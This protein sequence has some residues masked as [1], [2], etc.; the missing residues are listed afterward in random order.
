MDYHASIGAMGGY[1][2]LKDSFYYGQPPASVY[3]PGFRN[4]KQNNQPYLRGF[5]FENY[6][7]RSD[8]DRGYHA[9]SVGADWKERMTKPGDWF[10]YFEAYG[11][12]P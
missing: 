7:S 10:A 9:A 2:G 6:T 4:V 3:I 8:R 11:E 1:S 12:T 5:G